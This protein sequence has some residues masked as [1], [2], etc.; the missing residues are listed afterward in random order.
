TLS[1]VQPGSIIEYRYVLDFAEGGLYTSH[2]VLSEE[3]FTRLGKFSLKPYA[4]QAL[5][6]NW[7]NGLPPG[8]S[9]PAKQGS[10]IAL[11]AH[12]IPAFQVEDDMP[13]E[14]AV[15]FVVD[16]VYSDQFEKDSNE[17]WKKRG[18]K[19][20]DVVEEFVG[21]RK[22]MEQAVG[23]IV[24]AGDSPQTKAEKIYAR[25]Q[26]LRNLS[27]ETEKT[28]QEQ[29]RMK[30]VNNVEDV[31]KRGYANGAQLT[32]LYLG[33]ARAAGLEAYPVVASARSEGF[34]NPAIMRASDLNANVVLLKLD[35][36]DVYCDPGAAFTPFGLLPWG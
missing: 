2:W 18:K 26:Q 13:P 10:S 34:F 29:K 32:W 19:L 25:V 14:D 7:P 5:A 30:E 31:W 16:F 35:G 4:Q 20:N 24:A 27:Y 9:P 33:L 28:E 3:L 1:D 36:K 8:T 21:K 23:Q 22:A 11:E 17:F 6:W 15:R 12:N